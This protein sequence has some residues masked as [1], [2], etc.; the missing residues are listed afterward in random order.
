[1]SHG[2]TALRGEF[3]MK[4]RKTN[5][6]KTTSVP[7]CPNCQTGYTSRL[8]DTATPICPYVTAHNGKTCSKFVPLQFA[9][10]SEGE[11][12]SN[13]HC[14]TNIVIDYSLSLSSCHLIVLSENSL[15]LI[16]SERNRE[17]LFLSLAV[18]SLHIALLSEEA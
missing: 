5:K 9:Q 16:I 3:V 17:L 18:A 2:L 13:L 8:L 12:V 15:N 10:N 1:M 6:T 4:I 11:N 7:L 14:V